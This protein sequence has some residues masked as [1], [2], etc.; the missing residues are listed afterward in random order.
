MYKSNV[1]AL[2]CIF[3]FRF[4]GDHW[5]W[6]KL[7]HSIENII[8]IPKN[9]AW[10]IFYD[11]LKICGN[12]WF[13]MPIL[14]CSMPTSQVC[15]I[16]HHKTFRRFSLLP[17]SGKCNWLSLYL[18]ICI[19]CIIILVTIGSLPTIDT[20]RKINKYFSIMTRS[21]LKAVEQ[22]TPIISFCLYRTYFS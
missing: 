1:A 10:A 21:H 11:S 3:S 7:E 5:R 16:R 22:P 19:I 2:I 6:W 13:I 15:Y 12:I 17:P 4:D 9:S 8:K 18:T 20:Y 14:Y